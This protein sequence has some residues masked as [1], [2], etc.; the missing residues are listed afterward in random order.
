MDPEPPAP[1]A[2]WRRAKRPHNILGGTYGRPVHPTLVTVPIGAWL[3]SLVLDVGSWAGGPAHVLYVGSLWVMAIGIVGACGAAMAGFLDLLQ[4]PAGTHVLRVG[5]T[6]MFLNLTVT[7]AYVA[8]VLMRWSW[9]DQ[10]SAVPVWLLAMAAASYAL[11]AASGHLGGLMAYRYGVRVV[12]ESAQ[13][14]GYGPSAGL[15]ASRGG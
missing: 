15:P 6:H 8:N 7:T 2:S 10:V 13:R 11:L 4:I 5:C 1:S 14:D 9:Q 12:D 3:A